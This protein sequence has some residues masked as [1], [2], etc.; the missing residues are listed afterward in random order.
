MLLMHAKSVYIDE[1]ICSTDSVEI[2]NIAEQL[3][4][5]VLNRP[6]ELAQDSSNVIDAVLNWE[7]LTNYDYLLLVQPT[8]PFLTSDLSIR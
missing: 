5:Q 4:V 2:K 3:G 1:I 7:H 6:K 8:S